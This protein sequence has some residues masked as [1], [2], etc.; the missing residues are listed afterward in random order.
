MDELTLHL[1][2]FEKIIA[3]RLPDYKSA[4]PIARAMR[5]IYATRCASAVLAQV[6]SV[7]S[8][9]AD[10]A[11]TLDMQSS[12]GPVL[13]SLRDIQGAAPRLIEAVSSRDPDA[14]VQ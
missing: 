1:S 14:A 9:A 4:S 8:G 10:I 7:F 3:A 5:E 6:R 11:C 2:N 13:P 12:L